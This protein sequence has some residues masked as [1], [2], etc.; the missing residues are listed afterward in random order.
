MD[1]LTG[2]IALAIGV[3]VFSSAQADIVL[4]NCNGCSTAQVEALAP[5][6]AQGYAY[7]SDL[8]SQ[9]LYKVCFNW[10]VDDGQRPPLRYKEYTWAHPEDNA[11]QTWQAYENIYLNNGHKMAADISVSVNIP[12]ATQLNGDNGK[13]NAYDTVS[14]TANNDAVTHYL[15]T[16]YFTSVNVNGANAPA[17][18]ALAAAFASL[19]DH[20][21]VTTPFITTNPNFPV[22]I[23][24]VFSDGSKRTYSF[25]YAVQQYAAVPGTARDGHGQ[26]IPENQNMASNGGGTN[27]YDHTGAGPNYDQ[28]NLERLLNEFGAKVVN[29]GGGFTTCSW[30][31]DTN[32]LNCTI[33][34]Y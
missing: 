18:P 27:T 26:L 22:T 12:P 17:S 5:E 33:H 2:G 7:V 30:R 14:A 1:K 4:Q 32:T 9:N 21:Q 19:L 11:Q 34:P 8:V 10:D 16:T 29:G 24:V 20:F 28:G 6:C 31:P 15:D 25:N 13:I 3:L 23:V